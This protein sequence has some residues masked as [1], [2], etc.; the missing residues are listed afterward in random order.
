[1]TKNNAPLPAKHPLAG[2]TAV[3][4]TTSDEVMEYSSDDP[5]DE[6]DEPTQPASIGF[7][8]PIVE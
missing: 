4:D 6:Q 3:D 5:A 1:M 8:F 2:S 7:G